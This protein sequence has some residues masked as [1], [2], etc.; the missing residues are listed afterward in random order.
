MFD[1][2]EHLEDKERGKTKSVAR[3][4]ET[5]AERVRFALSLARPRQGLRLLSTISGILKLL[6]PQGA[7]L[8]K[9]SFHPHLSITSSGENES[10]SMGISSINRDTSEASQPFFSYSAYSLLVV[11]KT[12]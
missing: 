7:S 2:D 9:S 6:P 1:G 4:R 5:T 3:V 12:P 11:V 8:F 10:G